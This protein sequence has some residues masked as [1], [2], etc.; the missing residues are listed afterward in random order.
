[1]ELLYL[2]PRKIQSYQIFKMRAVHPSNT[3]G[4]CVLCSKPNIQQWRDLNMCILDSTV[5]GIPWISN[6]LASSRET[7]ALVSRML[8]GIQSGVPSAKVVLG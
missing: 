1:M 3:A 8:D 5:H 4:Q 7:R 6:T 2:G